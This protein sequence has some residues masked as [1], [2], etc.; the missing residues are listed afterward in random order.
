MAAVRDA[1]REDAT[2]VRRVAQASWHAAYDDLLGPATVD[3][4]VD[5]WY[6]PDAVA[7]DVDRG[8]RPF[9]VA[10]D[11]GVVGF[12]VA[13][14][15]DEPAGWQLYRLYVHPDEWGR[16]IGTRLLAALEA[17]LR[18]RGGERLELTTLADNEVAVRFYER[19]G[20]DR[21][22][23]FEDEAGHRRYRYEKSLR[24]E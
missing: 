5:A 17:R 14:P 23:S 1:R 7:D 11:G 22:G 4:R 10:D 12:A 6:A 18:D 8:E 21:V 3:E 20:F 19:R 24:E 15:G 13:V 16:G 9:L 2:A